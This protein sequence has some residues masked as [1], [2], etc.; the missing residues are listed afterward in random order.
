MLITTYLAMSKE[1]KDFSHES[2]EVMLATIF[3]PS[4]SGLVKDDGMP[5]FVDAVSKSISNSGKS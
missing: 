3:R 5:F 2:E 4:A 1:G